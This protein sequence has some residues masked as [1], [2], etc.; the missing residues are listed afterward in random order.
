MSLATLSLMCSAPVANADLLPLHVDHVD[1]P[2]IRDSAGRQVLLRGVNVNGLLDYAQLKPRLPATVPLRRRDFRRM[3]ALGFDLVRIPV[4]WSRLE[5]QRGTFN[6][7]YVAHIRERVHWAAAQGIYAV[8]DLHQDAWTK[9]LA[10]PDGEVCPRRSRPSQGWDGAPLWATL[11]DGLSTCMVR[12]SRNSPAVERA[13]TSFWHD[14]DGIQSELLGTWRQLA[15]ALAGERAIAGWDVFNEPNSGDLD[16]AGEPA[17]LG[18]F[19]RSAIAAIREGESAAQG[20][21]QHVVFFEP[22]SRWPGNSPQ[23][24]VP[25]PGFTQDPNVVYAP[26]LYAGSLGDTDG[27]RWRGAINSEFQDAAAESQLYRAPL[28]TGEYGWFG[29]PHRRRIAYFSRKIDAR[30]W[31]AAWWQWNNACGNPNAFRNGRDRRPTRI[32]GNLYR[33]SCPDQRPLSPLP[34]TRRILERPYPRAAP[35]RLTLLRS[36]PDAA[37]FLIEGVAPSPPSGNCRLVIWIPARGK[38]HPFVRG[39]GAS[40]LSIRRVRGGWLA[41][42]CVT[43]QYR[44]HG[45]YPG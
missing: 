25:P 20:G 10:T 30:L 32:V 43:G 9:Y 17:L 36:H 21:F 19:Y 42:A 18:A 41:N 27:P 37:R 4:N 3:A 45:G 16:P 34:T 7:T 33:Y 24:H 40:D 14:R 29:L 12:D 39:V 44:L 31:G 6:R 1:S 5:P 8:V 28:V 22:S 13:F 15:N 35:G 2:T 26:H 23:S 11:S 38:R